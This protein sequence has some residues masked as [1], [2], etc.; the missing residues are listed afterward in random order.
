MIQIKDNI[1]ERLS[2]LYVQST[3]ILLADIFEN[4]RNMNLGIYK[5]DPNLFLTAQELSW[6]AAL[7]KIK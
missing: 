4:F 3:T 1:L 6:Y 2:K 7:N 5:V